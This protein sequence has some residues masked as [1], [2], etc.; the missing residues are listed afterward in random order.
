M[1]AVTTVMTGVDMMTEVDH[2]GGDGGVCCHHQVAPPGWRPPLLHLLPMQSSGAPGNGGGVPT[3]ANL[4]L[5]KV[6]PL[7][8]LPINVI[9]PGE[10]EDDDTVVDRVGPSL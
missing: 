10:R 7:P 3:T 9:P 5:A 8:T 6:S 2:L 4:A 1:T